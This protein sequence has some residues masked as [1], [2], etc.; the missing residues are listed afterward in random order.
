MTIAFATL[1]NALNS[2]G[3]TVNHS[4]RPAPARRR[5]PSTSKTPGTV[6][7]IRN[8]SLGLN[9][10][11]PG[12]ENFRKMKSFGI[13]AL[14]TIVLVAATFDLGSGQEIQEQ[15]DPEE[16]EEAKEVPGLDL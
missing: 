12:S 7:K 8:F 14:L 3:H 10:R 13:A 4:Q 2:N 1:E 9:L 16:K 6:P 15:L 11:R 5:K